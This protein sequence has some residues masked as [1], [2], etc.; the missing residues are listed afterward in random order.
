M[1]MVCQ[2]S[3][4]PL[5]ANLKQAIENYSPELVAHSM[6]TR[7]F[8]YTLIEQMLTHKR[9]YKTLMQN[10]YPSIIEAIAIHDI[11]KIKITNEIF[12]KPERLTDR[13]YMIMQKHVIHG[14]GI[15]NITIGGQKMDNVAFQNCI[16]VVAYHHEWYDGK[17]Y[18]RGLR[19]EEIPLSAR[20]VA[21]V[22]VYDALVHER[23]YKAAMTHKQAVNTIASECG[24]HFDP[25]IAE[26][27]FEVA[28]AINKENLSFEKI[29]KIQSSSDLT[30]RV[31]VPA[32]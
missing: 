14:E 2:I 15:I 4:H 24:T 8:A 27:F 23:C 30:K 10:D 25:Q 20:I 12:S 28:D 21:I 26:V 1:P 3:Q 32:M 22:D 19:G 9:F 31:R 18:M 16:D 29:D 6:R 5:I 11:G 17:G 13:E 7:A